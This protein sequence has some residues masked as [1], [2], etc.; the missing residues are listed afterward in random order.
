[1]ANVTVLFCCNDDHGNFTNTVG[2]IDISDENIHILG[3]PVAL[4]EGK[5]LMVGRRRFEHHGI[6]E[7]VGNWCWNAAQM[8]E[9]EARRLITYLLNRGWWAEEYPTE[10]PWADLFTAKVDAPAGEAEKKP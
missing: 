10:G 9:D 5:K 1:M 6:Q 4:H 2:Q 8:S 3:R 7:W